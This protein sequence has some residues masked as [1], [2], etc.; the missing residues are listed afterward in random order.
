M[1]RLMRREGIDVRPLQAA[2]RQLVLNQNPTSSEQSWDSVPNLLYP[3]LE[4]L[5]PR[6]ILLEEFR[7]LEVFARGQ[8]EHHASGDCRVVRIVR[9][10][11]SVQVTLGT[12]LSMKGETHLSTLVLESFGRSRRFDLEHALPLFGGSETFPRKAPKTFVAQ[13]RSLYVGMSRPTHHLCL[14]MNGAR[15]KQQDLAALERAGWTVDR[16]LA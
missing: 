11:R 2:C 16:I 7:A 1:L 9:D 14:A 5:I 12:V 10:G 3:A 13:L 15:S 4:P 8:D 6:G